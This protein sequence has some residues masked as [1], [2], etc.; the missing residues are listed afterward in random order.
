M[1]FA[2]A[3]LAG[4]HQT[5]HFMLGILDDGIDADFN[6]AAL[7]NNVM[8]IVATVFGWFS[9][10]P[11]RFNPLTPLTSA[12]SPGEDAGKQSPLFSQETRRSEGYF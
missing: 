11:P 2:V 12:W 9:V 3:A 1:V 6:L 5:F 10:C 4:T 8:P 7:I